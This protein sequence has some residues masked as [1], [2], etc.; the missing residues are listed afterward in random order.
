[1]KSTKRIPLI[2]SPLYKLSSK[3]DLAK[4][5]GV[6]TQILH[7]FQN[8]VRQYKRFTLPKPD[9]RERRPVEEPKSFIKGIHK[10]LKL[11]LATIEVPDYLKS[12]VKG[13][14]H[15][16]NVKT[17]KDAN[18][19][20]TMDLQHFYQ[21]GRKTFL[22]QCFKE[23][24]LIVNDIAWLLADLATIPETN[25]SK[26]SY[27]PTGS[28]LSQIAIFWCYKKTFD[29]IDKICKQRGIIFSLYV[30][31]MTFSSQR[32]IPVNGH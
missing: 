14:S 6:R 18:Y 17:H 30:D 28:P 8:S 1:M 11:I 25:N 13:K 3:S 4:L 23:I 31:D 7:K 15:I 22:Y 26:E 9:S 29:D 2:N 20:V 5:L 12:G 32:K 27:F 16:D 21:T 10:K 24:F 19:C